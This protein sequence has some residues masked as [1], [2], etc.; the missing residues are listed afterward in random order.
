M[1][2]LDGGLAGRSSFDGW[3]K[4]SSKLSEGLRIEVFLCSFFYFMCF[5][6]RDS[7]VFLSL[8]GRGF[9]APTEVE[10][11]FFFFFLSLPLFSGQIYL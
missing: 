7:L 2:L 4:L 11:L 5:L 6:I 8:S 9:L 1:V 10:V 3:N